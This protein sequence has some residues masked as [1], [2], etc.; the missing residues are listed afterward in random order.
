[1][2]DTYQS[3]KAMIRIDKKPTFKLSSGPIEI[4][5]GD[6]QKSEEIYRTVFDNTGAAMIISEEDTTISLANMECE[7]LSGYS[8]KQLENKRKWTEFFLEEDLKKMVEYHKL[9]RVFPDAAPHIYEANFIDRKRNVK[10]VS[11][12]VAMLPGT[13]RSIISILDIT[14]Q[15]ETERA[16]ENR[17]KEFNVLYMVNSHIRIAHR[18][19]HVLKNLA[20]DIARAF[21]FGDIVYSEIVF[22]GR[23]YGTKK[24]HNL[25]HKIEEPIVIH[26]VKRGFIRVGYTQEIPQASTPFLREEIKIVKS[27][28]RVLIKHVITRESVLRYQKVVKKSVAGIYILEKNIIRYANERFGKIF[29]CGKDKV[30]GRKITDF[31]LD[32]P[33]YKKV[34]ADAKSALNRSIVKGLRKDGETIDLEVVYQKM[35]Y[36]GRPAAMGHVHDITK[37]KEAERKMQNFND[38]LK[39]LVDEKTRHLELANKRLLSLNELKDEF[40]AVTSHE[41]RSPL[42]SIRG[43]LSFLVEKESLEALPEPA[44]QYLIKAYNNAESLN[45]LVNNILDVSRLDLGRFELQKIQIDLVQMIKSMIDSLSFQVNERRINMQFFNHTDSGQLMMK[46]D[47]IRI[48]QVLRNLLDNAI[49]YSPRGKDISVHL[50]IDS[51]YVFIKIRDEGFGIPKD[52]INEI[53][54]KFTQLKGADSRYKTGAGLGLFIA[55][56]IIEMHDGIIK[57][58]S[59]IDKGSVFTIQLPLYEN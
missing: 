46:I 23:H 44:R 20:N 28:V 3:N 48:S 37:L 15:K 8:K 25:I 33:Y 26:G 58:E 42:T 38:E 47:P 22:D 52:K 13:K 18:L 36:H 59:E 17:L 45:Y 12:T 7:K 56:R 9:R 49:K 24:K 41:L 2:A 21:R 40:I 32:C 19:S 27:I 31:I 6:K 1:M 14:K 54:D 50:S 4:V 16:L 53:F 43:Y 10:N 39:Q 30:V 51:G 5:Y 55:K 11:L 35:D 34:A 57:V 29:K